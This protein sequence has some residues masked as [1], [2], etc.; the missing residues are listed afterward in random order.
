MYQIITALTGVLISVMVAL[1]GTLS[2]AGIYAATVII[3]TVSVL[4]S[5]AWVLIGRLSVK[6]TKHLP[7]WMY[8][9]GAVSVLSAFCSNYAFGKISMIA[10]TALGLLA[11]TI[12]SFIIDVFGFFGAEKR[13][14]NFVSVICLAIALTGIYIMLVGAEMNQIP[15][16][17][18]SFGAGIT[19]VLT[20]MISADLARSTGAMSG[21]FITHIFGLPT[22]IIFFLILGRTTS[23]LSVLQSAP[24]WAYLGGVFGILIV[25]L[26]NFTVPK[27]S[28]FQTSL[29]I[30]IGQLFSGAVIDKISGVSSSRQL[31]L[32][33]IIVSAGV[34]LS[35]IADRGRTEHK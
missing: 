6:P 20:R 9:A 22:A 31:L 2:A 30:F 13:K 7:W 21:A 28:A 26:N 4:F 18:V 32:G 17:L 12:T 33:G 19:L 24:W 25:A 11:Q 1:N 35:S 5:G 8:S 29:L 34:I 3:Y 15:A 23:N 16:L 14:V 27:I 10:I